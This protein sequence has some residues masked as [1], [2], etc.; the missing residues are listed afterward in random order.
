MVRYNLRD[1]VFGFLVSVFFLVLPASGNIEVAGIFSDN[2]VLQRQLPV[3]V[4]GWGDVG[5]NV[6]VR[7]A[8]KKGSG[9]C[10]RDG[11][12]MVTLE[13]SE[14]G[15]PFELVI[16]GKNKISFSNVMFGEVW[17]CSGQSNMQ[18]GI[19][20][21]VNAEEEIK[22]ADY[23]NIRLFSVPNRISGLAKEDLKSR[24]LVCSPKTIRNRWG[25]FSAVGYFFGRELH[26]EVGVAI[27]LINSS[28]GGSHIE[29]WIPEN[30]FGASGELT[31]L[32]KFVKQTNEDY[33]AKL[34]REI[35]NANERSSGFGTPF[36]LAKHPF[37]V[38]GGTYPQNPTCLYNSMINPIVGFGIRGAIWYQGESNHADGMLYY[39]KMKAL[40]GSWRDIWGVGDF[41][42]YYA[43]LAPHD[44]SLYKKHE[45]PILCQAQL[46][47]L[48]IE[49]TG[50]AVTN[51]LVDNVRDIHP[52]N[53]QD[54]G[55]RLALWAL[56]KT[57]GKKGIVYSG[58]LFESMRVEGDSIRVSF[59]HTGSG[60]MSRDEKELN[61]FE[62]AGE[63]RNFVKANARIEGDTVVVCSEEIKEPA[64]V[65]YGWDKTAMPNLCN[66]EGLPASAFNTD[67]E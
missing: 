1:S 30:G 56:A 25:S 48:E 40:I 66:K 17:V 23:P 8:G 38:A 65:R 62:I 10:G 47:A 18:F 24:W 4:W 28:W 5:E 52:K 43:Q 35:E 22:N 42:F 15:G 21:V 57:Y 14:A 44:G 41:G 54:V 2:M 64:A 45:L 58:P 36:V 34:M 55:K 20:S 49:N 6:T 7:I 3:K 67:L 27:G 51:D 46:K 37:D 12:W 61:W 29:A 11:K 31:A 13:A 63:D 59:S 32:S 26:K 53:K 19:A 60:L 33:R 50:M 39:E 9:V 16:E